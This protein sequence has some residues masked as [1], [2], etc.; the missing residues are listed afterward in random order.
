MQKYQKAP[1]LTLKITTMHQT[2]LQNS[3]NLMTVAAA[4]DYF[5]Y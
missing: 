3:R 1:A 2:K 5:H 4:V